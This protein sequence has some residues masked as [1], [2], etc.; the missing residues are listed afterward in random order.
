M[1]KNGLFVLL[2][3][4][5][6]IISFI[7]SMIF[8]VSYQSPEMKKYDVD[9]S[10]AIGTVYTDIPYGENQANRYDIYAPADT[11]KE[12]YGLVVYLHA[13]GFTSGDKSDD[14]GMLQWLCSKGYVAVGINYT[15]R[16]ASHPDASVYSQSMEI[17]EAM[18]IVCTKV[19]ELGYNIDAMAVAGGSA[20]HALAMLYAYRDAVTS[21]VPVK[22]LFGAVGPSS[23][24]PEDWSCYG[25]DKEENKENAA[26][27]FSVM[28][29]KNISSDLFGTP[30]YDEEIK[31][32]S[33]L[34]WVSE[35]TVPSVLAYGAYDKIQ[36]YQA[37]IRLDKKLTQYNILHEYIVLEHSGHGLQNDTKQNI[38]Y[39]EKVEEYLDKYLPV[40]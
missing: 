37:S 22:L 10:D 39:M 24:Y 9:W 29:G 27:L 17:K 12:S 7:G 21:P 19:K 2:C 36:S 32:I 33:A 3:I 26:Q 28:A 6:F 4:I 23:F 14:Q 20:G 15:L 13:G 40:K 34:L 38:Q 31:D 16:D 8:K 25:F 30:A 5:S 18:P 35:K 11:S 1:R